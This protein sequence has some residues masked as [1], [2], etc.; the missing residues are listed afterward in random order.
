RTLLKDFDTY[1]VKT[2]KEIMDTDFEVVDFSA[3]RK[4]LS[5]HPSVI[6]EEHILVRKN[7]QVVAYVS[8]YKLLMI[9]NQYLSNPDLL[10]SK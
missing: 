6:K 9:Y 10:F 4:M 5:D 1:D 3:L 2:A 8:R 7:G